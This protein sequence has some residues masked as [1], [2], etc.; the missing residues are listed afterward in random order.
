[1]S[2]SA[3][4]VSEMAREEADY[5]SAV[6]AIAAL[7]G[8]ATHEVDAFLRVMI[9]GMQEIYGIPWRATVERVR[10][11]LCGGYDLRVLTLMV[12]FEGVAVAVRRFV[13]AWTR[14]VIPTFKRLADELAALMQQLDRDELL[15]PSTGARRYQ[16]CMLTVANNPRHPKR[17]R[18][19]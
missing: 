3:L 11:Y 17:R 9:R 7:S 2:V 16:R 15:N 14:T 8:I 19:F 18:R 13:E 6:L 10:Q 5:Q 4:V 12:T 1:M